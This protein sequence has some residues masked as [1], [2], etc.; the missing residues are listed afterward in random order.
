MGK[1]L[2]LG[3]ISMSPERVSLG[4]E[5]EGH[6]MSM[7]RK[8]KFEFRIICAFKKG[9]GTNSRESGARNLEAEYQKQSC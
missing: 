1:E 2:F 3:Y 5:G 8:Q 6:S 4:E 9:T 7:D